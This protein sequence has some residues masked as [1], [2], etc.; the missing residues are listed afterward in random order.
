MTHSLI[1][2]DMCI[3]ID[4]NVG[5]SDPGATGNWI[6]TKFC[7]IALPLSCRPSHLM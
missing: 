3:S 1:S 6:E 7:G 4:I 2:H 5:D